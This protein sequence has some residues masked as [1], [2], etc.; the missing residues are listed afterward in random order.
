MVH[1]QIAVVPASI[2]VEESPAVVPVIRPSTPASLGQQPA[3]VSAQSPQSP[4]VT[5]ASQ[6]P[7]AETEKK[8]GFWGRIFG[9]R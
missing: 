4:P 5:A 6:P 8:R 1:G 9:K 3:V 2:P 7:P